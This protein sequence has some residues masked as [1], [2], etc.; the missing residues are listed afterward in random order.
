MN[1]FNLLRWPVSTPPT[2]AEL[3]ALPESVY[4]E[5]STQCSGSVVDFDILSHWYW[6]DEAR[7]ILRRLLL[8]YEP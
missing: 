3:A 7:M 6:C 1:T 4:A 2:R 8:R 5:L